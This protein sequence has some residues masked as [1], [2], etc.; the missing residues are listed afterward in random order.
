MA[1]SGMDDAGEM[2]SWYV[3]NAIGLY[4]YSPADPNISSPCRCSDKV[5]VSL[6]DGFPLVD[7]AA[8]ERAAALRASRAAEIRSGLVRCPTMRWAKASW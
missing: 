5:A 1:L 2:S 3:F 4:T 7:S 6:G 8:R